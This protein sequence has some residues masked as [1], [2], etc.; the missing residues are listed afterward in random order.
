MSVQTVSAIELRTRQP[1]SW[2]AVGAL[3]LCVSALIASEF[4]PVSLLTPI[5]TDLN[6]TEGQA[7]QAIAFSGAFAVVT[8]LF[9][10]RLTRG[11][12]RRRLLL[13]LTA[14]MI[15]SGLMVALAPNAAV[16]MAGRALIGVVVGGFWSMSAATVMRLVPEDQVPRAL[17]LL[18]GGNA[19]ATTVAAPLG[20]FLG[21]YIG[22]RGAFFLVVPLG[23]LTLAWQFLSLPALPATSA[24]SQSGVFRV[25]RRPRVAIGMAA[26][27]ALFAGRFALFTYVRPFLEIITRVSPQ[28]LSLVLLLI[29]AAG[30]V[31]SLVMGPLL[32]TSLRATLIGPPVAMAA[33]ALALIAL[34]ASPFAAAALL[35]LWGL[36]STPSPTAWWTWLSRTLPE[37]AEAGG[38]LMVAII[39]LAI[40]LGAALGG[41]LVDASGYAAA[42]AAGAAMLAASAGLTHIG[43][44]AKA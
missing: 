33:L 40:T 3:T 24:P 10:A 6:I 8:S 43:S 32:R 41:W 12:D 1:A 30:L 23:V 14:L 31:G 36:I 44:R 25:L 39:Q 35:T 18:N 11:L 19:L 21:H 27:A 7:G 16:F 38:G 37:D 13:A 28:A 4:L 9:I 2:G 20:S 15:V 22:W 17:N 26:V 42:F 5:A 29:G 34:G